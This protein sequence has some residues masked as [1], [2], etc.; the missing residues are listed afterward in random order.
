MNV[1][2]QYLPGLN[3]GSLDPDKEIL[4]FVKK[5]KE[6]GMDK[7]VAEKQKQLDAWL[8]KQK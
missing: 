3:C 5:L 6:A 4:N 7:I 2:N 1:I 8:A